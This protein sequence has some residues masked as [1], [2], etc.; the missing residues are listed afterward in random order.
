M[1]AG[2]KI[3]LFDSIVLE[4]KIKIAD[5]RNRIL[6]KLKLCKVFLKAFYVLENICSRAKRAI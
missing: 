5:F 6:F 4:K 3:S 1:A 2:A